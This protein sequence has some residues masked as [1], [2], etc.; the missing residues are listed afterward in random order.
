MWFTTLELS[1]DTYLKAFWKHFRP[2]KCIINYR[3][4]AGVGTI[5]DRGRERNL[6][7]KNL[8][9]RTRVISYEHSKYIL[10]L[11]NFY[12]IQRLRYFKAFSA[13]N[14]IKQR[15]L[16]SRPT[17]AGAVCTATEWA[18]VPGICPKSPY[19]SRIFHAGTKFTYNSRFPGNSRSVDTL[20]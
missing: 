14:Q 2:T 12:L 10:Q 7:R 8:L 1:F 11:L 18:K 6:T 3:K 9:F 19:N 20:L 16:Y 5:G 4:P 13:E 17:G 15:R